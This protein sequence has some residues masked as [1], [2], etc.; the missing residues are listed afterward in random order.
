MSEPKYTARKIADIPNGPGYWNSILVG[1]FDGERQ[2]GEYKR[3]YATLFDT[4]FPFEKNGR[5][6]AL[7][8]RDY[9]YTRVMSLPD[10]VDLG[11]EDK[12]NVEYKDHF[13]P[14]GYYVPELTLPANLREDDPKPVVANHDSAKWA[15]IVGNRYYWPD[16]KDGQNYSPE[17]EAEYLAERER[18]HAASREWHDRHPYVTQSAP[19][20]FVSGC[21]WGD[22]S[23][24]WKLRYLDLSRVDEGVIRKDSRFGYIE[25]PGCS[26]REAISVIEFDSVEESQIMIPVMQ[27][28]DLSGK[29]CS[30]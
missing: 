2:I 4:F 16:D 29:R 23:G 15:T 20:G 24:G 26:L 21:V 11:G 18:S 30:D 7:Y 1:V 3:N 9:M 12:T 5:W 28:F 6:F 19:F 22:D 10:C 8:S 14:T 17:R 25:L 27:R 13:C